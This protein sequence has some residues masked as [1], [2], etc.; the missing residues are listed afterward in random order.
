MK[1]LLTGSTGLIGAQVVNYLNG[2]HDVYTIGRRQGYVDQFLD[3]A[4]VSKESNFSLPQAD[5][6]IHCA[7]IID[8]DFGKDNPVM[9]FQKAVIGLEALIDKAVRS[10]VKNFLY[11]SS[12][13]V[14][15]VQAGIISEAKTPD[16]LSSYALAHFCSEQIFRR[17]ARATGA[18]LIVLR[19]N[20]VFGMPE[21]VEFFQRWTLIPFSFPL[22]AKRNGLIRLKSSGLQRRNFVSTK[23]IA[24]LVRRL[25]DGD[26]TSTE[27][28][29]NVLGAH[30]ESV[31]DFAMRCKRIAE[32]FGFNCAV[33]RPEN[34][35]ALK[36]ANVGSDFE[37][38]SSVHQSEPQ[39]ELDDFIKHAYEVL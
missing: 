1:I 13:H 2:E 21:F 36:D 37:L 9:G 15:G 25:V 22:E 34:Y 5:W 6:L 23:S 7:G 11:I 30:T 39:S 10:G 16:P 20:A 17:Y 32:A 19:P 38:T 26:L 12:T 4:T 8:E 18:R 27:G 31:Y 29:V 35:Q 24:N 33:E 28:V 3:L 14:Y